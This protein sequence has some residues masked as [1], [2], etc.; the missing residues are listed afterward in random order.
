MVAYH[1]G[2]VFVEFVVET[3]LAAQVGHHLGELVLKLYRELLVGV[4]EPAEV[5]HCDADETIRTTRKFLLQEEGDASRADV[6]LLLALALR[7]LMSLEGGLVRGAGD[8]AACWTAAVSCCASFSACSVFAAAS[9]SSSF[10]RFLA[11]LCSRRSNE[12]ET[13]RKS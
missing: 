8:A 6:P 3:D 11:N 1:V 2:D 10:F 4:A 5:H 12:T 13:K 9:A 7:R